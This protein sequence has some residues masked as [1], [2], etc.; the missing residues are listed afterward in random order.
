MTNTRKQYGSSRSSIEN[1]KHTNNK[2][3]NN[4]VN[5]QKSTSKN[6]KHRHKRLPCA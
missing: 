1:N 2:N 3:Y 5:E 6:H 4:T